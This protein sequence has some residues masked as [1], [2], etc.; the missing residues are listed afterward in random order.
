MGYLTWSVRGAFWVELLA[1][2]VVVA[3]LEAPVAV[4]NR[5]AD[6]NIQPLQEM[7]FHVRLEPHAERR[8]DDVDLLVRKGAFL[9]V[10][11][12]RESL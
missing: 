6:P 11:I 8:L 9:D 2:L 12:V 1:P 3:Q 5:Y 4:V 10:V 7:F